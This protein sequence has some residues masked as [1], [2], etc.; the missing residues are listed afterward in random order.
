MR[1]VRAF[2]LP[3][4]I[5]AVLSSRTAAAQTDNRLAV[6]G[7]VTSRIAGSSATAAS[8]AIGFELRLGHEEEHWGWVS[9]FFGWY[10]MDLEAAPAL[11]MG[12]SGH[13]RVRP[14]LAGYGHTWIRGRAAIT[15]DVLGGFAFN[16]FHLDPSGLAEYQ[17]HGAAGIDT[18]ATNTLAIKPEVQLWYDLSSRFGFKISGGYLISRPTVTVTSTL[19]RDS[20]DVRA[21]TILITVGIVYSII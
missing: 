19:G 12:A 21:D 4:I 15:A 16:S 18:Q 2:P 13:L 20:R 1:S 6:G 14:V 10:D 11:Q 3:L 9:S 17:R 5:L 7:S 8:S